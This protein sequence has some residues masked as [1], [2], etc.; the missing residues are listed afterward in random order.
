M[1]ESELSSP[2]RLSLEGQTSSTLSKRLKQLEGY[3]AVLEKL[4]SRIKSEVD[5]PEFA[6]RAI[7][8]VLDMY[9]TLMHSHTAFLELVR[10][11]SVQE[12]FSKLESAELYNYILSLS[13]DKR[14]R[15]RAVLIELLGD[16]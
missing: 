5:K 13:P 9:K 4:E 1:P 16:S 6:T 14:D 12:V 10:K 3:S 2:P 7:A 15:L 11:C 8:D